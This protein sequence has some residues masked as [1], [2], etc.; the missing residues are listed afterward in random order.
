MA[1]RN[2]TKVAFFI[3]HLGGGGAERVTAILAN[4][5]AEQAQS[6]ELIL[7][8]KSGTNL[9]LLDPKVKVIDLGLKRT[10]FAVLALKKHLQTTKPDALVSA[11]NHAN[12]AA[13]LAVKLSRLPI[14]TVV[15]EHSN[16]SNQAKRSKNPINRLMPKIARK[17]YPQ[18][19]VVAGV[20]Q[21]VTDD[22][23][24]LV[25][26]KN[27][28]LLVNPVVTED[29]L[30]EH[31]LQPDHPWFAPG[32]PPVILSAGRL[33]PEKDFPTLI[34]AMKLL[35]PELGARLVILGEGKQRENLE[36]LLADAAFEWA[37]PG[38]SDQVYRAMGHARLYVLSSV[39]EGLPGSLIEAL[40]CGLPVVSTDCVSGPRE[41]LKDGKFGPLVPIEDPAA[42]AA[43]I[44]EE[45]KKPKVAPEK[46]SWLPY[47]VQAAT[48]AYWKAILG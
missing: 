47:T 39:R 44:Q 36:S 32:Q 6:V 23:H 38:F 5:I 46:D 4:E 16:L 33:T 9:D 1:E 13:L 26:S 30:V 8:Q 42:L 2:Q 37:L 34:A 3:P 45:L 12:I 48:E 7:V 21:G 22:L 29:L 40:A 31:K 43:A 18:A 41:I 14:R 35:P 15:V 27:I 11:L 24:Q 19:S 17:V 10:L 25:G 28:Q 20:S